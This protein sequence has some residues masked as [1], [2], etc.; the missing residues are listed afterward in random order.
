MKVSRLTLAELLDTTPTSTVMRELVAS[1]RFYGLTEGGI[2]ADEFSLT[3]LGEQATGGDEV[4][5]DAAL[6]AAVMK[7]PPYK[8]FFDAFGGKKMPSGT[9]LREFL[10]R[11]AKVPEEKAAE[12]AKYIA[13]DAA[14]AGLRREMKG[15]SY[16]DLAGTPVEPS[17]DEE[18]EGAGESESGV[19]G[20]DLA[21]PEEPAGIGKDSEPQTPE[22]PKKAKKVF[23][24]HGKNR[25]PLEQLKK[26][27][28]QFK[29][30]YEP[31]RI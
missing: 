26:A 15:S 1:S 23:I 31:G 16:I 19:H 22:L 12:C 24:A 30:K 28:D 3:E 29:V 2:N 8:V 21:R 25:T 20:A 5:A 6:K 18:V 10:I 17:E 7:V 14:T 9:P 4:A 27:L 11:D 13:S